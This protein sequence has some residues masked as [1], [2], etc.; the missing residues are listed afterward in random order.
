[1]PPRN[2]TPE[3]NRA[4][5]AKKAPINEPNMPKEP[6]F[7]TTGPAAALNPGISPKHLKVLN[8]V[9]IAM[10][11]SILFIVAVAYFGDAM[12]IHVYFLLGLGIIFL[13]VWF[14]YLTQLKSTGL[15]D[16]MY[17]HHEE[18]NAK[19]PESDDEVEQTPK[20]KNT[21]KEE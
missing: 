12:N 4:A 20:E 7:P 2:R 17:Q 13:C 1:M 10:M 18:I 14:W 8:I 15:L 3:P 21:E 6:I 5:A 19:I 16:E 9:F 11:I